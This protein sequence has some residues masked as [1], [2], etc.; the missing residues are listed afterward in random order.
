MD[1]SL[2]KMRNFLTIIFLF[3]IT[4]SFAQFQSDDTHIMGKF[5]YGTSGAARYNSYGLQMDLFLE[6]FVSVNYNFDLTYGTDNKRYFHTPLGLI[7][8]P[9]LIIF[10]LL[11]SDST[12]AFS[13]GKG[14]AVLGLLL[15]ILPDGAALHIPIRDKV[16]IS[17]YANV[18]GLDFIK[19]RN[20]NEKWIKYS[21]SLGARFTYLHKS[22]VTLSLYGEYRKPARFPWMKGIG[23]S[24]GYRF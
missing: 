17:P 6:D 22:G 11:S 20:T 16:D 9:P 7:G 18:L 4:F 21:L 1:R 19:D 10:G 23:L 15:L 12:N 13:L 14:G 24:V 8:G 3:S 2:K 5:S